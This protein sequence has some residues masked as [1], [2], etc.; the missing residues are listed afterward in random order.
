MEICMRNPIKKFF[1]VA[2]VIFPFLYLTLS[3]CCIGM[4]GPNTPTMTMARMSS[5]D[6]IQKGLSL[7]GDPC[8][9]SKFQCEK[10]TESYSNVK[11]SVDI[12]KSVFSNPKT[13]LYVKTNLGANL[14]QP[15]FFNYQSPPKVIQNSLPLFL[16][17]SVLRL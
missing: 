11:I 12:H 17:I 5:G 14:I 9:S 13:I 7:N 15:A 16:Q 1:I 4:G 3:F 6:T 2:G 8:Q 10:L